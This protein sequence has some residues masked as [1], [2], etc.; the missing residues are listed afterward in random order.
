MADQPNERV[1]VAE[2]DELPFMA[3]LLDAFV[4]WVEDGNCFIQHLQTNKTEPMILKPLQRRLI[5][6]MREQAVAG[7]PVRIVGLKSRKGGFS[8]VVQALFYFMCKMFPDRYCLTLAHTEPSTK[9]MFKIT[10]RI[11]DKD[12][13]YAERAVEERTIRGRAKKRAGNDNPS[14]PKNNSKEI[15]FKHHQSVFSTR[16][17]GG[18]Y[19]GSS[20]TIHGLHISELAKYEGSETVVRDQMD[21]LFGSVPDNAET[22]IVIE[23]TANES[24]TSGEFER[25][26]KYAVANP[27][28]LDSGGFV[29]FFSGWNEEPAYAL[30]GQQGVRLNL[31][32]EEQTLQETYSLTSEQIRWRR[33]KIKSSF[34]G[35]KLRFRREF[36][37]SADEAFQV[38]RGK[39]FPSL[40]ADKHH[41]QAPIDSLISA[42]YKLY[43]GIDFGGADAFVC[44]WIAYKDGHPNF[45]IDT[46]GCPQTW[47]EFTSYRRDQHGKPLDRDNHTVDP[48]RYVV[49]HMN[50]T[51]HVHVYRELYVEDSAAKGMDLSMLAA[52][53]R[54]Q[55]ADEDIQITVADRSRPD[56]ILMLCNQNIPACAFRSAEA[57]RYGEI[58]DG[59][60]RL[61]S[62][63]L[64]TVPLVDLPVP[65]PAAL[66]AM[67]RR[68]ESE[69]EYGFTAGD[70][71]VAMA[72]L[73]VEASD[74][75]GGDPVFGGAFL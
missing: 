19:V 28:D 47:R 36:P 9:D 39:V 6:K 41:F 21:S 40:R 67:R 7:V 32:E 11:S 15:E 57:V 44:V 51:G 24:D 60:S 25:R 3:L 59:I 35:D 16:T 68:Q 31:D 27:G 20:A 1:A 12:P 75:F 29:P 66:R 37:I 4:L 58:E 10:Q 55:T 33:Y 23:S 48:A 52:E 13:E 70:I 64:A 73:D 50:L 43:R 49:M 74:A 56:S 2:P 38:A 46:F 30:A 42:G 18:H 62:L 53:I 63:M 14:R 5:A 26:Y 61:N 72:G 34:S 8:T 65:E 22:I 69:F 71:S 17:G 45:T 54:K